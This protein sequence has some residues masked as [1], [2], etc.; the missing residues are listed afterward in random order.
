MSETI[1]ETHVFVIQILAIRIY[2]GFRYSVFEFIMHLK[3][4]YYTK[5]IP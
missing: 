5:K 2:F 1:R 4:L 3:N